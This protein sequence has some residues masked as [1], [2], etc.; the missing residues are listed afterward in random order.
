MNGAFP[1]EWN[2]QVD[3]SSMYAVPIGQC[4]SAITCASPVGSMTLMALYPSVAP[5]FPP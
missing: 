4:L 5:S 2:A 3:M 1:S